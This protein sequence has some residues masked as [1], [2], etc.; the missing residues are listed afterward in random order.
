MGPF[1]MPAA[2]DPK[3]AYSAWKLADELASQAEKA[4]QEA[5]NAFVEDQGAAPTPDLVGEAKLL[6]S[7]ANRKLTDAINAVSRTRPTT[8]RLQ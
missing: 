6:R 8:Q 7:L 4:L 2:A 1:F 5:F 3:D